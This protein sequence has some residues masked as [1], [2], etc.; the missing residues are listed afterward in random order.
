MLVG[1]SGERRTLKLVA[2]HADACNLFGDAATVRHKV[3]VL[4][5][6]C[7]DAGRDVA[8]VLVT[9]LSTVL[10]GSDAAE[11]DA[12]VGGLAGGEAADTVRA[13]VNAGTVADHVGRFRELADAGI[14]TAIVNVPNLDGP[15]AVERFAPVI[16]AFPAPDDRAF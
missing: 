1:G 12:L 8:D 11:V 9:H 13:R 14:A 5:G 2:R 16:A 3:D 6:H 4:T 7:K 15:E 10:V